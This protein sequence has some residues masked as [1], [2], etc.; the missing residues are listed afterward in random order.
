MLI[1]RDQTEGR[2]RTIVAI[3]GEESF[4]FR[5]NVWRKP[6]LMCLLV[7][8]ATGPQCSLTWH[9]VGR[10]AWQVSFGKPVAMGVKEPQMNGDER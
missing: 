9:D 7:K 5:F 8:Y 6:D 4:V 3:K 10:L 2:L 1:V